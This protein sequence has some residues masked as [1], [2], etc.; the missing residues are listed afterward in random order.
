MN[1]ASIP[2]PPVVKWYRFYSVLMVILYFVVLT[3]AILGLVFAKHWMVD[4]DTPPWLMTGYLI[5]LAIMSLALAGVFVTGFFLPRSPGAW[6]FHIVLICLG[7]SS[8]CFI[9]IC[10]PLLIYWLQPQA[11]A[12]F[13][14]S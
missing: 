9:P 4:P 7:L 8:P 3:L 2:T 10:V 13:G 6:S 12:Y 1:D 5:F 11:K 14:R